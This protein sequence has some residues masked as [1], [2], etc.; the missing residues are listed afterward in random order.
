MYEIIH[1]V[2]TGEITQREFTADEIAALEAE[3]SRLD[4][5]RAVE[6]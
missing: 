4:A 3:K 5:E 1:D 2:I 6:E